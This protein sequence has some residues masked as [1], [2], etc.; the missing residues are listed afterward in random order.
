[1]KQMKVGTRLALGFALVLAMLVAVI[2]LGISKLGA[3]NEGTRLMALDAYPKVVLAQSLADRI[4]RTAR[5]VRDVLLVNDPEAN[6]KN[7]TALATARKESDEMFGKLG[8]LIRSEKGVQ[9]LQVYKAAYVEYIA[10]MD[11][12]LKLHAAGDRDAA[13]AY[14][15]GPA[16]KL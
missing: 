13:T 10:A 6:K 11:E 5:T 12:V 1:M 3:L 14:L 7:F 8:T 2:V 16:R 9:N 4:N 15:M